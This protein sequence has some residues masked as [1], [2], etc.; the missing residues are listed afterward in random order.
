M[1][2]GT[3][4]PSLERPGGGGEEYCVAMDDP[5]ERGEEGGGGGRGGDASKMKCY[6]TTD[7][8]R[9]GR[10]GGAQ[11]RYSWLHTD[12][13]NVSRQEFIAGHLQPLPS[14]VHLWGGVAVTW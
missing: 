1:S 4:L 3:M 6:A 9:E 13:H 11:G 2:Q 8:S 12:R 10:G 14:S 7:V 5:S